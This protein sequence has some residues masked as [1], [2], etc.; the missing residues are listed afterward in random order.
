[1]KNVN[2]LLQNISAK[3]D[4]TLQA[5]KNLYNFNAAI[6]LML[7]TREKAMVLLGTYVNL[8]SSF[9]DYARLT[10]LYYGDDYLYYYKGHPKYTNRIVIQ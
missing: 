8:E 3:G 6:F 10:Q 1:M 9:S 7:K 5:F 2:T 4:E